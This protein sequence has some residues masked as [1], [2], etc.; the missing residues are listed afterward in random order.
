MPQRGI[1]TA[2]W[3]HAEFSRL[4]APAKLL[5]LY[6]CTSLRGNSAGMYRAT[7]AQIAFDTSLPEPKLD[8]LFTE[9]G[10]IDIT[11]YP[12]RE[13]IWVRH[14]LKHQTR[15]DKFLIAVARAL[16][17]DFSSSNQDLVGLFM[18]ENS[19][20]RS[21]IEENDGVEIPYRYGIDKLTNPNTVSNTV[22]IPLSSPDSV[23]SEVEQ[24]LV[25]LKGWG[26]FTE[27]DGK[28]LTTLRADYGDPAAADVHDCMQHW[29]KKPKTQHTKAQWKSRLR[30][31]MRN[32]RKF[33]G[34]THGSR[35]RGLSG[36]ASAGAFSDLQDSD[37]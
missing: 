6:C 25:E 8:G 1:D 37:A 33:E 18:D 35:D 13:V 2:V 9:I 24:A 15:S 20:F 16:Q 29:M 10:P 3:S 23:L 5:F 4:S 30:N 14:F 27:A 21:F 17:H 36:N 32:K 12:E 28:W 26:E 31:W 7:R 34:D 19:H 11:W 22:S